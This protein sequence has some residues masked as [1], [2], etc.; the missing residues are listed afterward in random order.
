M[1]NYLYGPEEMKNPPTSA[2]TEIFEFMN[3]KIRFTYVKCSY[4]ILKYAWKNYY[5]N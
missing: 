3:N 4:D 1:F 5:Y 2:G